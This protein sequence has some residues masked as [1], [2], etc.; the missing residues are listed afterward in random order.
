LAEAV[1]QL[2]LSA[3]T[4]VVN[5]QGDEPLIEPTLI[6]TVAATLRAHPQA[7]IATCASPLRSAEDLFSP[8][9]VKVVCAR[10]GRALYFSRAPSPW[11]REA[12]ATGQQLLAPGLPA[13]HHIGLYAYRVAFLR[14]FP[15]LSPGVLE[16]YESLEQ[17]RA[18]EHG[19]TIMVHRTQHIL[20][21][22]VDTPT[23]LERVRAVYTNKA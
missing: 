16:Q 19:H 3:E 15:S 17:L 9:V 14:R 21:A 6:D 22:G 2:G 8:H 7:D 4:I 13:L 20:A 18:I 12:L 5:V 11:A 10:N 1:D 23:D